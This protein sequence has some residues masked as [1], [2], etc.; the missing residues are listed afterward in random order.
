LI[1]KVPVHRVLKE[2]S[3]RDT[4]AFAKGARP[5]SSHEKHAEA[6]DVMRGA[7]RRTKH[8]RDEACGRTRTEEEKTRGGPYNSTVFIHDRR[9]MDVVGLVVR[10]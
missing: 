10:S 4:P 1:T 2:E 8:A 9:T 5:S 6:R 7:G 3:P